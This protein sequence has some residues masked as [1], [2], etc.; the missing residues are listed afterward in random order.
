[1]GFFGLKDLFQ[2]FF[3]D[4]AIANNWSSIFFM[5]FCINCLNSFLIEG[6]T[7]AGVGFDLKERIKYGS[8]QIIEFD[9]AEFLQKFCLANP[10]AELVKKL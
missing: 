1:M 4:C 9:I 10:V 3:L 6:K 7:R 8:K 2:V 5:Q